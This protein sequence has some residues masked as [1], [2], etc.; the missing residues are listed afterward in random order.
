[1][2]YKRKEIAE[3]LNKLLDNDEIVFQEYIDNEFLYLIIVDKEYIDNIDDD[4]YSRVGG[5]G[6]LRINLKTKNYDWIHYLEM[7]D[8]FTNDKPEPT[9]KTIVSNIKKRQ[10]INE[11]DIFFF[12][13]YF[14]LGSSEYVK[15]ISNVIEIRSKNRNVIKK[16]TEL[17]EGLACLFKI[18]NDNQIIVFREID[19]Q[20][21]LSDKKD[22]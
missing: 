12:T 6:P 14:D 8:S 4:R 13:N 18:K 10:W 16:Y 5:R 7:P 2:Y 11:T 20:P 17:F 9:F 19:N 21:P 1:M 3:I 22:K 15:D